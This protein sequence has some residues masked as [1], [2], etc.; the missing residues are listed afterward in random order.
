M[1]NFASDLEQAGYNPA[2][3]DKNRTPMKKSALLLLTVLLAVCVPPIHVAAGEDG[4]GFAPDAAAAQSSADEWELVWHDEFDGS[5]D[6]DWQVW[7]S[8]RGFERN[9]EYQW[10]QPQNAYRENGMLVLE[11]RLDSIPNPNYQEGSRDWRRN[12]PFARY[13]SGS[14]KTR[15]S[16]SFQYGRMEV[17]AS[18]PAV[19]GS[20]PA[21]WTLG[22]QWGWPHGGEIDIM[23][24]YLTGKEDVPTILANV[25]WGNMRGAEWRT[26][27]HP[28]SKFLEADPDW[29]EKYHIWTM[30]WTPEKIVLLLDGEVMNTVD[31]SETVNTGFRANGE[32]PFSNDYPDFADYILLDHAI[33]QNGGDPSATEFP[34]RYCIDYVRVYQNE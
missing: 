3:N 7:Q 14:I 27:H 29:V 21:I 33:G 4:Q 16:F 2:P 24:Y 19:M 8:E 22:N 6:P 23:E 9:E 31:L 1:C 11:A 5:G 15:G 17:R 30:D 32:N 10:Y 28:L 25:A 20:W 26:T 34:Q 13:S 12:R 18:I